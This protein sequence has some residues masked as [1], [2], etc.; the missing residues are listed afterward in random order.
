MK[1]ISF[2]R[3]MHNYTGTMECWNVGILGKPASL[4]YI[5]HRS[6]FP[7]FHYSTIPPDTYSFTV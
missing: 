4:Y 2:F 6:I 5:S 7:L 3:I 1:I